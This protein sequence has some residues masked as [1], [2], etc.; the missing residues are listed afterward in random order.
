MGIIQKDALRTAFLSY[1]GIG[2]GTINRA[3]LFVICLSTEQIG[4][5]N[6][7]VSV[8]LLFAQM[9]NLGSVSSILKFFPYFKNDNKK[10]HGF[11]PFMSLYVLAGISICLIVFFVFKSDIQHLYI[12][13]SPLFVKYYNWVL[14]IGIAY[15]FFQFFDS[16]LRSL[17]KNILSV[18]VFEVVLRLIISALLLLVYFNL[19]SFEQFVI[20]N[21]LIYVVPTIILAF[22]LMRLGELDFSLKH[23]KISSKYKQ[24][25]FQYSSYN[26]LNNV[27]VILITTL[28]VMM[29][30]QIIGLSATGVYSTVFFL[31]SAVQV[32]YKSILKVATPIVAEQWKY[33]KLDEMQELYKKVSSVSLIFGFFSFLIIWLNADLIFSIPG[34][35]FLEG[36]WVFLFLMVGRLTDMYCGINGLIFVTSKK[37]KYEIYFTIFMILAV[38]FLN[39]IFIPRWGIAGAAISTAI[40][41][42]IYN[43]GRVIFIFKVYKI[44]PF[45]IQQFKL[46]LL[47]ILTYFIGKAVSFN[48]EQKYL[49]FVLECLI[50]FLFFLLPI[51]IFKIET[52]SVDYI[53]KV[54]LFIKQKSKQ[55]KS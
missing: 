41:I 27:G 21:S 33:R 8:G 18:F 32:P 3:V 1:L 39:L 38:Y 22:Y 54:I 47:A 43:F 7:I 15:V 25:L 34:K 40:A 52:E 46:L 23:L 51:Y 16:H 14:P 29:I 17:Q 2:I 28:D 26:Y 53:N 50:V 42:M 55:K 6:L 12:Q 45:S 13:K 4:L 19:I 44:H 11:I 30:A 24:I 9:A 48:I 49:L 37:Y 31:V 10:H 5:V 20:W 35:E 36:I